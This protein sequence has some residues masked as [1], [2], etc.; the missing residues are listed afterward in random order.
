MPDRKNANDKHRREQEDLVRR[1]PVLSDGAVRL[2]TE[3]YRGW[4]WD[5][6]ACFPSQ[7]TLANALG[8][9]ESRV[10][11]RLKELINVGLVARDRT[12]RNNR[13][14]L[15]QEIPASVCDPNRLINT[16]LSSFHR[17]A[18]SEGNRSENDLSDRSNPDIRST[19]FD[20]SDRS[21]P[22]IREVNSDLSD[23]SILTP[24]AGT[25]KQV[26]VK[27]VQRSHR[28][29]DAFARDEEPY[30]EGEPEESQGRSSLGDE[31]KPSPSTEEKEVTSKNE[32]EELMTEED[33]KPKKKRGRKSKTVIRN[34]NSR[35]RRGP[36]I[37]GVPEARPARTGSAEPVQGSEFDEASP[38]PPNS[39]EAILRLLWAET[40]AKYGED[41]ASTMPLGL[42][43]KDKKNLQRVVIDRYEPRVVLDMI[44]LLVWDWEV[45]RVTCFPPREEVN[46]PLPEHLVLYRES[47]GGNTTTGYARVE[48]LRGEARTYASRYL[49]NKPVDPDDPF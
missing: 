48:N 44:R 15:V 23:R 28:E 30:S 25:S 47:L 49:S 41:A 16:H 17:A 45:I 29:R 12:G 10:K 46:Y 22:D 7:E 35:T 21:N 1:S 5:G 27:Q 6:K 26:Q 18:S 3:L 42:T 37:P 38:P 13:Y 19:T 4:A 32:I 36:G 34:P 8:W 11:R 20:L 9:S 39:P 33:E 2:W 31:T 43:A 14:R 24:K 40:R